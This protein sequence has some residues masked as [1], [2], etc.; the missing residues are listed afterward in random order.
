[1]ASP[2][3][4]GRVVALT[5]A[6]EFLGRELCNRLLHDPRC[7]RVVV[8]DVREPHLAGAGL[9]YVQLDLTSPNA[10]RE[11]EAV[12]ARYRVDTLVHQAFLS[13][14]IHDLDYAHELQVIGTLHLLH[15]ASS[16]GLG[17]V[18]MEGSTMVY[19]ARP[20][21][22]NFIHE[23]APLRGVSNCPQVADLIAAEQ[24]LWEFAGRSQ[25]TTVTCLRLASMLGLH[26]DGFMIRQLSR[27]LVPTVMGFDPLFQFVHESDALDALWLAWERDC[28]GAFNIAGDGVVPLSVAIR[29]AGRLPLPIPHLLSERLGGFLWACQLS[30]TPVAFF[31]YLRYLWVAD[32]T[33]ARRELGFRPRFSSSQAL[34]NFTLLHRMLPE[35]PGAGGPP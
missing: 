2:E 1:M 12:F 14:P 30:D 29:S 26:S 31:D 4:P 25:K 8:I 11:L 9:E 10:G 15:A 19:G 6:A 21:N 27:P 32:T 22:P 33:R 13:H 34:Q 5:G 18:I 24:A 16:A 20:D 23:D 28:P 7:R 17:K 35:V 3:Q